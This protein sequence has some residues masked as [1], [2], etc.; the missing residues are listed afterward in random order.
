MRYQLARIR[1]L[2]SRLCQPGLVWICCNRST[3]NLALSGGL[4]P[5][6]TKSRIERISAWGLVS[7]NSSGGPRTRYLPVVALRSISVSKSAPPG[8]L[9][10]RVRSF[11][12]LA[13]FQ[14]RVSIDTSPATRDFAILRLCV[15]VCVCV[16]V[17]LGEEDSN[18][19]SDLQL[20]RACLAV[21]C[22][23]VPGVGSSY[24]ALA[25]Q[26]ATGTRHVTLRHCGVW[27]WLV[28]YRR[29]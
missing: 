19:T 6:G 11:L 29:K 13:R 16:C 12:L 24:S 18:A 5:I 10:I 26:L 22:K 14:P 4:S 27:S 25:S 17:C 21:Y 3:L 8:R 15:C 20:L 7:G 9:T 2:G 28:A 23:L 1:L